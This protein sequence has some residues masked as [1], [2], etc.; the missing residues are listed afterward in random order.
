MRKG[1]TQW[2]VEGKDAVARHHLAPMGPLGDAPRSDSA[3]TS[4]SFRRAPRTP[5]CSISM[6]PSAS[7]QADESSERADEK[8]NCELSFSTVLDLG[9]QFMSM[10]ADCVAVL[11]TGAAAN[12]ACYRWLGRRNNDPSS[13]CERRGYRWWRTQRDSPHNDPSSLCASEIWRRS[14]WRGTLRCGNLG[15]SVG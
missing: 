15:A 11:D 4:P 6:E 14:L 12:V 5:Y 3:P 9:R 8:S 13:L 7:V 2:R 10:G 1:K